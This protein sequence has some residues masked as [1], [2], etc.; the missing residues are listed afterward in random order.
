MYKVV[1]GCV[2]ACKRLRGALTAAAAAA[3]AAAV[4]L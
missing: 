4:Y 1:C 3:A 2:R